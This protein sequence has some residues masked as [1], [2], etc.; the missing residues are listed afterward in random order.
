M[1]SA[2]ST[3]KIMNY[4]E[5]KEVIN[6]EGTYATIAEELFED[7]AVLIGWTDQ[8]STHFDIFFKWK[9]DVYGSNIQGGV[10]KL[11]LF[12]SIMRLGAFGFDSEPEDTHPGYVDEKLGGRLGTSAKPLTDLINGVRKHLNKL[13]HD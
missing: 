13:I 12:V 10:N 8:D 5:Y 6:G 4:D 11:D 3:L 9:A 2:Q 1:L 7:K